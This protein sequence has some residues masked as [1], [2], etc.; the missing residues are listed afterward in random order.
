MSDAWYYVDN[1]AQVGPVS[2]EHLRKFLRSPSG[3]K[4]A[5]VWCQG[6]EDWQTAGDMAELAA[7][8]QGPPPIPR[9][10]VRVQPQV[11]KFEPVAERLIVDPAV[12]QLPKESAGRKAVGIGTS[13][14][15]ALIG[16]LA[17]RAFGTWLLWPAALIGIAWFILVKCK[18]EAAAVPM[19]AVLLGHTAWMV[20]GHVSFYFAGAKYDLEYLFDVAIVTGLAIWFFVARSR[21]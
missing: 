3:G 5:L 14:V 13:I 10:A 19:V 16:M 9:R 21:G 20:V 4:D 17:V 8:F 7:V 12:A 6:F 11:D 18:I 15:G 1:G 2:F